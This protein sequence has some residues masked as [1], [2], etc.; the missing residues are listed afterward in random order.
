MLSVRRCRE[1]LGVEAAGRADEEIQALCEQLYDLGRM[2]VTEFVKTQKL[3]KPQS[4]VLDFRAAFGHFVDGEIDSIEERAAI[5]EF[6][7]K[8]PR[9][10]AERAAIAMTLMRSNN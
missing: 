3:A 5:I 6:D 10:E 8:L 4:N 1:L 7:G 9:D 2:A